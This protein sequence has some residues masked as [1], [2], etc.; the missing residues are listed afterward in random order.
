VTHQTRPEESEAAEVVAADPDPGF[1]G[2]RRRLV[3]A[4]VALVVVVAGGAVA[5]GGQYGLNPF[6]SGG[7]RGSGGIDN[8]TP[9]ATATVVRRTLTAQANVNGTLGYTGSSTVIGQGH[10]T[11]TALPSVGQVIRQGHV[12]YQVNGRPVVLL[13]GTTPAFRTLA[14]DRGMTGPDVRELNADLADLGYGDGID[15]SSDEFTWATK[16]AVE[17]L[18]EHLG[19]KQ[20]G[21][22][23]LGQVVFLPG[24]ARITQV[25]ASLGGPASG[26]LMKASTPGRQVTAQLDATQ[27]SQL[28]TGDKVTI[29][30]PSGRT[31]EGRVTSVGKVATTDSN[32]TAKVEVDISPDDPAATGTLDQ[33][34]VQIAI[35]TASVADALVV[36]VTALVALAGGG[37]AVEV[38]GTGGVRTLVA[39]TIGL[40][41]DA[42]GLVQVTGQGLQAGQRVV[43]PAS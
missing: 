24:D 1:R 22:L 32:G 28:A 3:V 37:Y 20:T 39:V 18:Q 27:Q 29:T 19:V 7:G 13:H 34:P 30:L 17:R 42:D 23:D 40:F 43:V 25:Q 35:T 12:L 6:T 33:A 10:G 2:P 14:E 36:P 26:A 4:G 9:T 8:A 41:D 11:V 16:A 31:T 21:R 5:L 38:V 15:S